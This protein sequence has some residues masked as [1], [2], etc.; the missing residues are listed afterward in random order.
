MNYEVDAKLPIID[1]HI[2]LDQYDK[3]EQ[4]III[5]YLERPSSELHGMITVSMDHL[6]MY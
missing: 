3:A 6:S 2:H 4:K 5:D 1:A